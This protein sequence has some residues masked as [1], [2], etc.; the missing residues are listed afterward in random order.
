MTTTSRA[1]GSAGDPFALLPTEATPLARQIAE[2][3]R[4][5]GPITFASFME[6]ALY[7]PTLG[8]YRS[9]R[10]TVGREGDFLT[11]PEVHPLFSYAVALLA[12]ALWEAMGRPERFRLRDVGA[13]T[14]RLMADVL[15]WAGARRPAFAAAL[16]GEVVERSAAAGTR[17]Q[18]LLAPHRG[19]LT[20]RASL[21]VCEPLDGLV[22]ANELLDA[23]PVHRLRWNGSGWG[24]LYVDIA[25]EGR[26]VDVAG[27]ISD[28]AL[29][30]P[31]K[32]L[33]PSEGQV[34]EVCP[35]LPGLV[36]QLARSV[37]SGVLLLFDYG[38][39]RQ[40]LY[41]GWRKQGTL[42]T[43]HR[44]RPGDDPFVRVGEQDLSCHVDVDTV[45][46]AAEGAGLRPYATRSQ[47]EFLSA[48]GAAST[49]PA[50]EGGQGAEM[51]AYLSRRRGV[52]TLT[53]P[54]GLGRIQVMAFAR[55][56]EVELPG[57]GRSAERE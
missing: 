25:A 12:A 19:G 50:T 46:A 39:P 24:E 31:L 4:A 5:E 28:A 47:A 54:G 3:I 23:Q 35:S 41:A 29:L 48:T 52:E 45:R 27:E 56:V 42:L 55:S 38:Y 20:W 7:D 57:L 43:F 17:R 44:H 49:P 16:R 2:R 11:S 9:G 13:G 10:T 15:A 18:P 1:G 36:A 40:R 26:F 34:V 51:E 37:R 22:V 30:G 6:A 53:D 14:G 33:S 32:G 21:D 8:Y